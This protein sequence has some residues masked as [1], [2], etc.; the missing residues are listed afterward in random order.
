MRH[1]DRS[2]FY[3]PTQPQAWT[4]HAVADHRFINMSYTLWADQRMNTTDKISSWYT[5]TRQAVAQIHI[6]HNNAVADTSWI[7]VQHTVAD[8][9]EHNTL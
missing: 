1:V 8:T 2:I 6:E 7:N 9:H 4:Q 3:K 5:W